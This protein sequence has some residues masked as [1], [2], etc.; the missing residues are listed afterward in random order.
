MAVLPPGGE[1][2]RKGISVY[3][4]KNLGNLPCVGKRMGA[5]LYSQGMLVQ[6]GCLW[7][8]KWLYLPL[9]LSFKG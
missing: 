9:S 3:W 7:S 1:Y 4:G 6:V 5:I 2:L 8:R